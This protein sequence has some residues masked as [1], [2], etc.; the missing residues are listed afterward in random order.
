[1]NNL[2]NSFFI[3]NDAGTGKL[4]FFTVTDILMYAIWFIMI[5]TYIFYIRARHSEELHYRYYLPNFFFKMTLGIVFSMFYVLKYGGG[6]TTA[7]WEVGRCLNNLLWENP[8]AYFKEFFADHNAL[9][10]VNPYNTN[11][12]YPPRWI[13]AEP[14]AFFVAKIVSFF[15]AFT[16]DGYLTITLFFSVLAA[17]ASWRFYCVAREIIPNHTKWFTIGILFMP[18]V[19]FWCSGISKDTLVMISTFSLL[20]HFFRLLLKKSQFKLYDWILVLFHMWMLYNIRSIVLM[21]VMLPLLIVLALRFSNNYHEYPIMKKAIR[22]MTALLAILTVVLSVQ[23][24]EK[25]I[26]S[27]EYLKEAIVVQQDFKLNKLYTGKRYDL[28][29]SDFSLI[30]V[31]KS[32]PAAVTAGIYRPFIWEALNPSLILNGL[33]SVLIIFLSIQVLLKRRKNLSKILENELVLFSL[34]FVFIFAFITGFSSIIFGVLVRLRAP[35]IPFLMILL[36]TLP[37]EFKANLS[38]SNGK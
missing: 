27:S 10:Y 12:G 11:T 15:V 3:Y 1:M 13:L 25:K 37:K 30:G 33:E 26:N 24:Y 21:A 18:S 38:D 22:R 5:A 28:D 9:S 17:S 7:Y 20:T 16:L 34:I 36:T 23:F 29:I 14:E 2:S 32:I 8:A 35:L 19:S 4:T 6:D 31:I